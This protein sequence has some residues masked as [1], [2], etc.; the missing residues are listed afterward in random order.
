M[1]WEP[2]VELKVSVRAEEVRFECKPEVVVEAYADS[3]ATAESQSERENLPD[4]LEPGVTYRDVAV[5]WRVV[6]RLDEPD[7][8][9]AVRGERRTRRLPRNA[10]RREL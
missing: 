3:P 8:E 2:D 7:W 6:A 1:E 9:D 4:V 10:P 5:S